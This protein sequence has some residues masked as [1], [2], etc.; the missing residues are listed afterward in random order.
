METVYIK[1]TTA[2]LD[3]GMDWSTWCSSAETISTYLVSVDSTL[4]TIA[5][6][7]ESSKVVTAWLSGG[8]VGQNYTV[9]K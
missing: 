6:Y 3:Y 7:S 8:T 2:E 4:L 5:T 1:N 9:A